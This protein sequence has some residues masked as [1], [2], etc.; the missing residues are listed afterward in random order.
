VGN[1]THIALRAKEPVRFTASI[2]PSHQAEYRA[3]MRDLKAHG[4]PVEMSADKI[5]L[6]GS[7]LLELMPTDSN[8]VVRFAASYRQRAV[9][10]I[11]LQNSESQAVF[12]M[13]DVVG[14]IFG[15]N[16]SITF[17]GSAFN[18][19]LGMRYRYT[20][21]TEL[22]RQQQDV[23][24]TLHYDTWRDRTL[25]KLPYFDRLYQYFECMRRG[26]NV[27]ISLEIEGISFISGSGEK[28]Y[29]AESLGEIWS[30]LLYLKRV[31]D[32]LSFWNKDL[33]FQVASVS[34][35]EAREVFRVWEMLL[36]GPVVRGRDIEAGTWEVVPQGEPEVAMLR[37]I[38]GEN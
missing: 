37:Q 23:E 19:I 18:G 34:A 17:E 24:I 2:A 8:G 30:S 11:T 20:Y 22:A 9:Q 10:K 6:G 7:A 3:K 1:S 25:R 27:W 16:E 36:G 13:D 33:P 28:V 4:T 5:Q 31:R 12:A 26:W 29:S 38:V 15:G 32:L 21:A 35:E 14:E